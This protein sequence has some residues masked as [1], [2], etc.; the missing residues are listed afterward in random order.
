MNGNT[1][2][3]T[4][5]EGR[6][7]APAPDASAES[8]AD[9]VRAQVARLK[10]EAKERT[11]AA[12]K[13]AALAKPNVLGDLDRLRTHVAKLEEAMPAERADAL[14][15]SPL[16]MEVN[17][18]VRT[19]ETRIRTRLGQELKV[20]CEG[21]GLSFRVV[22]REDPVEVRIPPLMLKLDFRKGQAQL[23]FAKMV[24]LTCPPRA[25]EILKA[26]A[27][28]V[29]S[30]S[31]SFRPE[32]CFD[33]CLA[34]YRLGIAARGGT[35][36]DRMEI[37]DFL[38]LLAFQRQPK[39][40]RVSPEKEHFRSY[41]RAR[42]AFDVHQLRRAGG[43]SRNGL[44]LGFGVATGISASQKDRVIYLENELGEGEYKLTIYFTR[45]GEP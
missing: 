29:R 12:A 42:F 26:H 25:E 45:T 3:F 44:R 34:A 13:L 41:S 20:A 33:D 6:K 9:R 37:L 38:P 32:S 36:G 16:L 31:S 7:E 19:A 11:G 27:R 40:F 5:L 2:E 39:K 21:A 23:G 35:F 30:L 4:G 8:I 1:P 28:V 22:S 10:A 17:E 15:L 24:V 18:H 43:L 14:G